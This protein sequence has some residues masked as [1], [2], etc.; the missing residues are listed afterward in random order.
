[1]QCNN[2]QKSFIK[3]REREKE[4]E[5]KRERERGEREREKERGRGERDGERDRERERERK[6]LL[7]KV[8]TNYY[9]NIIIEIINTKN[10]KQHWAQ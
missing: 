8:N 10:T 3:N 2:P 4:K 1:M 9:I 7:P 6:I 5:R